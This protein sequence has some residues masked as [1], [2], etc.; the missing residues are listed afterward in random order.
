[1]KNTSAVRTRAGRAIVALSIAV[2]AA[3]SVGVEKGEQGAGETANAS[4]AD[5]VGKS[6]WC[7]K[8][9]CTPSA[10]IAMDSGRTNHPFT[11]PPS[12]YAMVEVQTRDTLLLGAGLMLW[13][14]KHE[15]GP[16]TAESLVS[17]AQTIVGDCA[18][19]SA[20]IKAEY[21]TPATGVLT[22]PPVVCGGWAVR[23]GRLE[24]GFYVSVDRAM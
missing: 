12:E 15:A 6:P 23:S 10:P 9:A 11:M 17:F 19:A 14:E 5:I 18:A 21:A 2:L 4:G 13:S 3:C 8:H 1:M 22:A 24:R 7:V 16:V 20:H